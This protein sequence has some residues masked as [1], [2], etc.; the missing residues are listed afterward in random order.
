VVMC[1]ELTSDQS[2]IER[3]VRALKEELLRKKIEVEN[4]RKR[5]K[6]E[7][8]KAKEDSLKKKIEVSRSFLN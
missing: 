7:K 6:K 8:L 4:L 1:V 2:D 5:K 3:Q